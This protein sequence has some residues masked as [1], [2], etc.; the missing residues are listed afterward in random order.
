MDQLGQLAVSKGLITARQLSEALQAQTQQQAASGKTR[1]L[2]DLLVSSGLL[3]PEDLKGLLRSQ[4]GRTSR[5]LGGFELISRLGAGGMGAVYKARQ[6]SLDRVVALKILPPRLARDENFIKRFFREAHCVAKLNHPNIVRGIDVG[7]AAGYHY[8]AMEFVDGCSLKN[9]IES[10]GPLPETQAL[11]LM[12][13]IAS[14]LSHAHANGMIH[15]D[16]KPDNV[17]IDRQG[18]AKLCDLGLAR[19]TQEDSSL[20]QTGIAMGTPHYISPEQA[21]GESNLDARADLYSLGATWF[22][23]LTGRPPYVAENP[24]AVLSKHL[25]APVPRIT[26]V[27]GDISPGTE[28]VITKLLAKN[29]GDRYSSADELLK[30]LAD[31]Q[32]GQPPRLASSAAS[33]HMTARHPP[34]RARD[35]RL[36]PPVQLPPGTPDIPEEFLAAASAK[37]PVGRA[38]ALPLKPI[39]AAALLLAAAGATWAL[40]SALSAPED[41]PPASAPA[42]APDAATG[43]QAA[44]QP[45]GAPSA[46]SPGGGNVAAPDKRLAQLEEMYCLI[47]SRT[48]Q[49]PD[50]HAGA[51]KMWRELSNAGQGTKYRL[52]ATEELARIAELRREEELRHRETVMLRLEQVERE[53]HELLAAGQFAQAQDLARQLR[54]AA[55]ASPD[56]APRLRQLAEAIRSS[57]LAAVGSITADALSQA[58]AEEFARARET[59]AQLDRIGLPEAARAMA[60]TAAEIG[61]IEAGATNRR[62]QEAREVCLRALAEIGDAARERRFAEAVAKLDESTR[63]VPAPVREEITAP[64]RELLLAAE[65]FMSLARRRAAEAPPD[66]RLEVQGVLGAVESFDPVKDEIVVLHKTSR[67]TVK[68]R[69][70]VST[71][72]ADQLLLLAGLQDP[73]PARPADALMAGCFLVAA[74]LYDRSVPYFDRARQAGPIAEPIARSVAAR[75]RETAERDAADMLVRLEGLLQQ[76]QWPECAALA[77]ELL[78]RLAATDCVRANEAKIRAA[79]A[80]A[81]A[82]QNGAPPLPASSSPDRTLPSEA[83]VFRLE[84]QSDAREFSNEFRVSFIASDAKAPVPTVQLGAGACQTTVH[85]GQALLISSSLHKYGEQVSFSCDISPV[86]TK[87]AG[88]LRMELGASLAEPPPNRSRLLLLALSNP[89]RPSAP[90]GLFTCDNALLAESSGHQLRFCPRPDFSKPVRLRIA[91]KNPQAVFFVDGQ[92]RGHVTLDRDAASRTEQSAIGLWFGLLREPRGGAGLGLKISRIA[93]GRPQLQD[94]PA[95]ADRTGSDPRPRPPGPGTGPHSR[96]D[97]E[98]DSAPSIPRKRLQP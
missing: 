45:A 22:H 55:P 17:L 59:L 67:V 76:K 65:G 8:F 28:A 98:P 23:I 32:A 81:T 85:P 1:P 31:L 21:R 92:P 82:A 12:A 47:R 53:I 25:T 62:A 15:R 27:R 33:G 61:R 6:K 9:M 52:L 60:S 4:A 77:G 64:E 78:H 79:L 90:L 74:G 35:T 94:F 36:H 54:E 44:R 86:D 3:S 89:E 84:T 80:Q 51:E 58:R 57:A 70:P 34:V 16:I 63:D 69:G 5:E 7:E 38:P 95:P 18:V 83:K 10:R 11:G 75:N 49:H 88:A 43:P 66:L 46:P 30:D 2:G 41:A 42:S 26:S 24:L 96:D 71:L 50:D 68:G 87:R 93:I 72:S 29:P 97:G 14:G 37:E 73:A 20:T 48:A 91:W 39:A 40:R 56:T 13:Q 19:Q